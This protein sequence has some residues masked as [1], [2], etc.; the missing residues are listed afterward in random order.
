MS[1]D[2]VTG[3]GERGHRMR[4][5]RATISVLVSNQAFAPGERIPLDAPAHPEDV[6]ATVYGPVAVHPTL[7]VPDGDEPVSF[8]V[9]FVAAGRRVPRAFSRAEAHRVARALS[10]LPCVAALRDVEDWRALP[11]A[12]KADI[13]RALA[14]ARRAGGG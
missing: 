10:E 14:A 6:R 1:E 4:G 8:S 3:G 9:T 5:K 12:A 7:P 13:R 11:V 2:V